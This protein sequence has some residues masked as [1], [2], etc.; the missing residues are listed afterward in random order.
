ME[1]GDDTSGLGGIRNEGIDSL[2]VEGGCAG[3]DVGRREPLG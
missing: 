1:R 3:R 2:S